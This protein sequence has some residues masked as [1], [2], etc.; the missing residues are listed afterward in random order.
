MKIIKVSDCSHEVFNGAELEDNHIEI[1]RFEEP[2]G[3]M[4]I[5][6]DKTFKIKISSKVDIKM[7]EDL[8]DI[9]RP[10]LEAKVYLIIDVIL[11]QVE[12]FMTS[13][14][15][16]YWYGYYDMSLDAYEG[17]MS[18][19]KLKA[20]EGKDSDYNKILG[21]AFEPMRTLHGF[22][23]FDWYAANPVEARKEYLEA[24]EKNNFYSYEVDEKLAG[25]AIA[26]DNTIDVIAIDTRLQK[27]GYGRDFLRGILSDMSKRGYEHIEIGVV[28]SNSHVH[29]LYTSE[30]FKTDCHLRMYKNY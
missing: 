10:Y 27:S 24:H 15:F 17:K 22:E 14:G 4:I 7:T 13:K 23:P 29:R 26:I 9:L 30:G 3:F 18:F 21:K 2:S 12:D 8:E 1:F 28:E 25:V 20:Y 16:K 5:S 19:G 6:R 11:K